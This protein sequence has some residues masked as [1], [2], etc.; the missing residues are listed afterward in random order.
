MTQTIGPGFA[1]IASVLHPTDFSEGSLVAFYH[2]LKAAMMAKSRLTLL[3]VSTDK[4]LQWSNFPGVRETLERW[5]EL[6]KGSLKSAVG[7]LGI[8]ASKVVA[9]ESDPVD[10]VLRYLDKTPADLIVLASSQRGGR[11]P[12]LGKSVSAPVT[13]KAA[14]MTLLIPGE[15]DGFVSGEDGS[16]KLNKILIPIART[17][18]PEPALKAAARFVQKLKSVEGTFTVL[19]VGDSNTMPALS[20]PEVPGWT[21]Q[22]ELRT[23]E[24]IEC[25]VKRAKEIEADLVVMSTDGRNGFLDGLRG[26]HSER[27]LRHSATPLLTV[28][29][30]SRISRFL[31]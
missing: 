1:I 20:Y 6:P 8:E 2:A 7:Q 12:W 23:G 28:P 11:V 18:R 29:V 13:R 22:K 27:V 15:S 9:N 3:H 14:Q 24:V 21:W 19:H 10:A 4:D 5:G 16:V 31:I 25:I 26:S 17:P 30:G